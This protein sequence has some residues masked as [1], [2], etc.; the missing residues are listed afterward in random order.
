MMRQRTGGGLLP[1]VL[2]GVMGGLVFLGLS[3]LFGRDGG[4]DDPQDEA[5]A[6]VVDD[7]GRAPDAATTP[8]SSAPAETSGQA[9]VVAQPQVAGQLGDARILIPAL[10]V[11]APIV[12]TYLNSGSW[13]VSNLG[14]NVGHLEGTMW[15]DDMPGNVVLSGH[16][17]MRD[18]RQGVFAGL[19]N[20]AEGETILLQHNGEMRRYRVVSV[21][22]V[23]PDDLNPVRPTT[24]ERLTLITCDNYDFFQDSYLERTVIIAEPEDA[25]S[26]A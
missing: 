12:Q 8:D 21:S 25:A 15:L 17:E 13:D 7:A 10:A 22:N 18:G 6:A 19:E 4:S 16:V 1:L 14:M 5:P 9:Q 11:N 20:L 26:G 3:L 23:A 2:I 24:D